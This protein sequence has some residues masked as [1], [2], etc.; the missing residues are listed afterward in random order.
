MS[1]SDLPTPGT[2]DQNLKEPSWPGRPVCPHHDNYHYVDC[3]LMGSDTRERREATPPSNA[4]EKR[5]KIIYIYRYAGRYKFRGLE[6]M[7]KQHHLCCTHGILSSGLLLIYH[8]VY[9]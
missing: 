5:A 9:A 4:E 6:K 3:E 8:S 7:C 2:R 1:E